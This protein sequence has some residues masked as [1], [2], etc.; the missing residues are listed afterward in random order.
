MYTLIQNKIA[1]M[2]ELE[3]YYTLDEALK[4]Y[5]LMTM[6]HD[7]EDGILQDSQKTG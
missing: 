7:V 2:M 4:L 3:E 6:R 1:G 5:A